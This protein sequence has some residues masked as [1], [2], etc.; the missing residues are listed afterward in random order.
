MLKSA[1]LHLIPL[2]LTPL[3]A[4]AIRLFGGPERGARVAGIAVMISFTAA[5]VYGVRPGWTPVTDLSRIGHIALGA[6]AIGLALDLLAPPR[7]VAAIAGA[8]VV[9][10]CAWGSYTA[11]LA[12]PTA[13]GPLLPVAILA[14]VAFLILA[15]LDA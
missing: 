15:R 3:L 14:V 4:C 2:L 9:L 6:T 10:V 7:I 8:I 11:S 12:M 1:L 13:A 5:W